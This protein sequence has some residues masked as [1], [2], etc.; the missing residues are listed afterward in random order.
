VDP[1]SYSRSHLPFPSAWDEIH[2]V[3]GHGHEYDWALEGDD[4]LDQEDLAKPEIKYQDVSV[5]HP[6]TSML[7][8]RFFR[9]SNRPRFVDAC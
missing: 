5:S 6:F 2:G 1:G 9:S 7:T 4:E 3:F 8:S